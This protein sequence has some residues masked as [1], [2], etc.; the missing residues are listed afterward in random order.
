M[1]EGM[2]LFWAGSVLTQRQFPI[3][4]VVLAGVIYGPLLTL[5]RYLPSGLHLFPA[6]ATIF[7]FHLIY[8]GIPARSALFATFGAVALTALGSGL[9][10]APVLIQF[11]YSVVEVTSTPILSLMAAWLED[12]LL[13]TVPLV[14]QQLRAARQ[15][16]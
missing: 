16:P 10:A 14:W 7:L 12:T 11:G 4:K 1:P 5:Y 6:L 15:N 8:F 9:V 3:R 2:L 13:I